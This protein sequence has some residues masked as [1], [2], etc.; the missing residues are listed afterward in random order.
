MSAEREFSLRALIRQVR[1]ELGTGDA[2]LIAEKA[3]PRIPAASR[4][5]ALLEAVTEVARSVVV[6]GHPKFG[7]IAQPEASPPLPLADLR[8]SPAQ[9][10]ATRAGNAN[11][12]RSQK[13][14]AIRRMW[15]DMRKVYTSVD[16]NKQVADYSIGD[17]QKLADL[18][19]KQGR[20]SLAKAT[21]VRSL[22]AAMARCK[23]AKV[24]DLPDDVLAAAFGP[25][26][27]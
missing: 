5:T 6:S 9:R 26:A 22:A 12:A 15:P 18:L 24:R 11:S 3:V 10:P 7:A 16:A 4:E 1:D 2:R 14:M 8:P 23:A 20:Q 17:L 25:V 13:V 21:N 27:A 19:E